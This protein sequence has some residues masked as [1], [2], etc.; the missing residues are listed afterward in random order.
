MA[1]SLAAGSMP[2]VSTS[3][4]SVF[5]LAAVSGDSVELEDVLGGA[6]FTVVERRSTVVGMD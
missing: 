5:D 6:R 2:A 1:P 3:H 4:R